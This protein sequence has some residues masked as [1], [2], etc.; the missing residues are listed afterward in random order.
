MLM[1]CWEQPALA[2]ETPPVAVGY[3]ARCVVHNFAGTL[4]PPTSEGK[5]KAAESV[6]THNYVKSHGA[7]DSLLTGH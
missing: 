3:R 1:A 7:R 5:I 6:R 2:S 4:Y